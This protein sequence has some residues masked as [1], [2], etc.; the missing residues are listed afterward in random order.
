[1]ADLRNSRVPDILRELDE[2]GMQ[3]V[4]HD[5]Y[6]SAVEA[7]REYGVQLCPLE[8]LT[9]LDAIILAVAHE[10]YL[11]AG[12]ADLVA[13]LRPGGVLIDVKS[14]VR[15]EDVGDRVTLWSL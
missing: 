14:V 10:P 11:R 13:R 5:P 1:V 9:D 3:V 12:T 15:P 2:Y 8:E 4:V 6:G 7:Q